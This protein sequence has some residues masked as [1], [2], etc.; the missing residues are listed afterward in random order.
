MS[1]M[2][3]ELQIF[4]WLCVRLI[5]TINPLGWWAIHSVKFSHVSL[6]ACHVLGTIGLQIETKRIF[7]VLCV[8]T[9]IRCFQLTIDS[10]NHFIL[11]SKTNLR[12]FI[13]NVKE[14]RKHIGWVLHMWTCWLRSTRSSLKIK[15]FLKKT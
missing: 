14:P 13:L 3:N 11:L 8:K 9:N 5:E 15:V 7:N 10:L 12:M 4:R 2:K 6:L 1:I